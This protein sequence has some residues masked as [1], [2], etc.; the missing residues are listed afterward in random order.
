[1]FITN[2]KI[3][4]L[5]IVFLLLIVVPSSF[6][7]END[8]VTTIDNE[9][10]VAVESIDNLEPLRGS[11]DYYFDASAENDNGNGSI[12]NPYKYLTASRIKAN[13]N[14]Y[15]ADGEYN[16]DQSKSIDQVNIFSFN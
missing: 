12:D 8:T 14:I 13:A 6:A 15:L 4:L 2:K 16:L 3:S 11:N 9:S 7:H 5:L 10:A 1:M